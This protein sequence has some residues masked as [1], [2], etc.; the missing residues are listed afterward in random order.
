MCV[1]A[2]AYRY[3]VD[4]YPYMWQYVVACVSRHRESRRAPTTSLTWGH[5]PMH[6]AI[7]WVARGP[8]GGGGGGGQKA[9]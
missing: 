5:L 9:P 2:Y 3:W 8:G 1:C 6:G 7:L 4:S